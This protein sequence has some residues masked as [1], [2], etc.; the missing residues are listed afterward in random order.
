MSMRD[1]MTSLLFAQDQSLFGQHDA[2]GKND[3]VGENDAFG[4]NDSLREDDAFGENDAFSQDDAFGE[5]DAFGEH[6]ALAGEARHVA[7]KAEHAG[8]V[9]IA[10]RAE[11]L[12]QRQDA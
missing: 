5:N 10:A 4:E 9:Q 1:M 7:G 12:V 8:V 11:K 6:D 3:D 2:F